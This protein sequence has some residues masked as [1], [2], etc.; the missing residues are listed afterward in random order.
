M[1]SNLYNP[2]HDP[3]WASAA[4]SLIDNRLA[5]GGGSTGWSAAWLMAGSAR[6]LDGE[7]A[8]AIF[9]EKLLSSAGPNLWNH[10][11]ASTDSNNPSAFQIDG[12]FGGTAAIAEMLLQSHMIGEIYLLPALP[13]AAWA[14]GNAR[15]LRARG[16]LEF[17]MEWRGSGEELRANIT[18]VAEVPK[19]NDDGISLR[20]PPQTQ[21][22]RCTHTGA[23]G[24]GVTAGGQWLNC[25]AACF[26]LRSVMALVCG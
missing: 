22:E 13:G 25:S 18:R 23:A 3:Q 10:D 2:L 20:L 14:V 5:H 15:G 1:P 24:C 8:A 16:G 21:V 6:L 19:V 12:N 11:L 17:S 4:S 26:G 9:Y 7:A